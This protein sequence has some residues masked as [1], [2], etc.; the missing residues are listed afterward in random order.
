MQKLIGIVGAGLSGLICAHIC[1]KNNWPFYILASEEPKKSNKK[2]LLNHSSLEFLHLIGI[3]IE[4][5]S[6]YPSLLI[7]QRHGIGHLHLHSP[8]N[9]LAYA[10]TYSSILD[11]L[12]KNIDLNI[13]SVES[14][15]AGEQVQVLTN[16]NQHLFSDLLV[17]DGKSSICRNKLNIE[18][19]TGS[20]G[21][22]KII[23]CQTNNKALELRFSH[24]ICGAI[25][26]GNN[27]QIIFTGPS[28]LKHCDISKDLI[29]DYFPNLLELK[30][31][32]IFGFD[33]ISQ[34]TQQHPHQNILFLGDAAVAVS[35]VAAQGFN[36]FLSQATLIYQQKE[37]DLA[38]L[39]ERL[40]SS[41]LEFFKDMN[42]ITA[43]PLK[44]YLAMSSL[45]LFKNTQTVLRQFGN[46][47]A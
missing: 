37:I 8:S 33:F 40:F 42:T 21:H 1:K 17:C 4:I 43:Q 25:L 30:I 14:V 46:R 28:D 12:Y 5:L 38:I 15:A 3:E 16:K 2:I 32:H 23:H 6:S 29:Q 20:K 13:E 35:P 10:T 44:R 39:Q 45:P 26:P 41:N 18:K 24:N 7:T 9:Y 47:Y 22:A 27:S 31:H 19:N 36:H 11:A 34:M